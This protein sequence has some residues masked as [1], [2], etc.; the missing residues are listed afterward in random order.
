MARDPY[1]RN[2]N[3]SLKG[4]TDSS[5]CPE[6]GKPLVEVL[7]RGP[8]F[9]AG[10]RWKSNIVV[11]GLPLVHIA[12]GPHEDEKR[13]RARG[14]IAI[15][16]VATGWLAIGGMA[17]GIVA[18]GGLALGVMPFGGLA[19]GLVSFGGWAAGLIAIGGGALGGV[20]LGGAAVGYVAQGGGAAGVYADGGGVW[21]K[22]VSS[23]NRTDPEARRFF[24]EF[25]GIVGANPRQ[26]PRW[27]VAI[28]AWY[29]AILLLI[30]TLCA[31][32]VGWR[33]ATQTRRAQDYDP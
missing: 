28:A 15:G 4:L 10:T 7:E 22:Y 18:F 33:Y 5:K 26:G 14:I 12:L 29:I 23:P 24:S 30:C 8:A 3:Y 13:G 31:I 19:V 20:A 21:G 2:C 27:F 16:D 32:A 11:F 9:S 6:C 17:R 1:C 25:N